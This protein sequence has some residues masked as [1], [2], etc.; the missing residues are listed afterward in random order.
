MVKNS[1]NYENGKIYKIVNDVDDEIYIGSTTQPLS[2]RMVQHRSMSKLKPDRKIYEHFHKLGVNQF[3]IILI[4]NYP[5]QSRNELDR[6][7]RYFIELLKAELNKQIPTRTDKEY[8]ECNKTKISQQ[9]KEWKAK[10]IEKVHENGKEYQR[11]NRERLTQYRKE[12]HVLNKVKADEYYQ[13]KREH[14]LNRLK[15]KNMITGRIECACGGCFTYGHK[16]RH[17]KTKKHISFME[18]KK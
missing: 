3:K 16:A 8:Y 5:C 14:I 9:K 4:E 12:Y 1:K 17:E 13:Q 10:N 15:N 11:K 6:R 18:N 2:K 7:E